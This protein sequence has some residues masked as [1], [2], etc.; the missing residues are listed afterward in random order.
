LEEGDILVFFDSH[1]AELTEEDPEQL[2]AFSKC[3]DE[4]WDAVVQRPQLTTSAVKG[5][6][7]R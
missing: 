7:S 4:D 3:E 1:A 5:K 6:S 2:T